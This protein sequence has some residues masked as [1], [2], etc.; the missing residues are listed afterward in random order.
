MDA[1]E[2]ERSSIAHELTENIA[3]RVTVM[4]IELERLGHDL[5]AQCVALRDRVQ[6]LGDIA[7]DLENDLQVLARRLRP[8]HLE[9]LGIAAAAAALCREMAAQ[10]QVQIA[11][12]PETMPV[13]VPKD[14]ALCLFRVL[15]EAMTNAVMHSKVPQ[16]SVILRGD[17]GW[18]HLQ[19][20]DHGIGFDPETV[21]RTRAV[22]LIGM[23]ERVRRLSGE[24]T[25]ESQPGGGTRIDARLPIGS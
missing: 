12:T 17:S 5:P 4:T 8:A 25:I 19:V 11:F 14:V 9:F 24:L 3:H 15:Q 21:L 16:F 13:N 10:H 23:R 18:I 20:I 7:I 22:G 1:Q 2:T 6:R